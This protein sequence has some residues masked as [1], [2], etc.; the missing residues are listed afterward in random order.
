MSF[1]MDNWYID[2][3]QTFRYSAK[4]NFEEETNIYFDRHFE[5]LSLFRLFLH[6]KTGEQIEGMDYSATLQYY[7]SPMENIGL[8]LSQS[9]LGNTKYQH[10]SDDGISPPYLEEYG[11]VNEYVS[12]FSLRQNIWK[13]WFFYD[14]QPGVSF[15]KKYDY[16]ANYMFR[17][18][19][20]VH[21][22]EI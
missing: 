11:G 18:F 8:R 15:H 7:W 10:I 6:R 13:S 12:S 16:E 22:V 20:D 2:P 1:E 3:S 21:L 17:V 19:F 4:E 14:V 9:F 5:D